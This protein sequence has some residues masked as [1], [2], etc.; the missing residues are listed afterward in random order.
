MKRD[1]EK[2]S[3]KMSGNCYYCGGHPDEVIDLRRRV[4]ELEGE[5]NRW[6]EASIAE[7]NRKAKWR[8]A[9]EKIACPHVTEGPLWWQLEARNALENP[10]ISDG[11]RQGEK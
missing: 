5:C 4:A 9:L 6:A 2:G 7:D 3:A 8:A 10:P 11:M 1:R